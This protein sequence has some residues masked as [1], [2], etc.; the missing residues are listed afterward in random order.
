[1]T[2]QET[3]LGEFKNDSLEDLKQKASKED[4]KNLNKDNKS[5]PFPEEKILTT[6]IQNYLYSHDSTGGSLSDYITY[7][8][9]SSSKYFKDFIKKIPSNAEV[10][11]EFKRYIGG[12]FSHDSMQGIA[13]IYYKNK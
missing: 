5:K 1:M 2:N 3:Y 10:V 7:G 4:L 8:I 11:V 6:S 13:L 12:R 9:Y